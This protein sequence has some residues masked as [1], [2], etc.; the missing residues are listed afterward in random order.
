LTPAVM[1]VA[2]GYEF[3]ANF[4]SAVAVDVEVKLMTKSPI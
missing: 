3:G 1:R 2:V 4:P